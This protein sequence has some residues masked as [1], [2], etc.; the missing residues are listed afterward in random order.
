MAL[1]YRVSGIFSDRSWAVQEQRFVHLC[2]VKV[3]E[4]VKHGEKAWDLGLLGA[5]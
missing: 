5:I 3:L 1:K 2:S 4:L